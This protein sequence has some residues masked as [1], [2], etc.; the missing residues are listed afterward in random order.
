MLESEIVGTLKKVPI[1][2]RS[3]IKARDGLMGDMFNKEQGCMRGS[4]IPSPNVIIKLH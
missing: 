1:T 3:K 2:V 4:C